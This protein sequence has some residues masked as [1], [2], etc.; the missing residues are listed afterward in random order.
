M[1]SNKK[2]SS[3][4]PLHV[5]LFE[6]GNRPMLFYL[7]CNPVVFATYH[8]SIMIGF[9]ESKRPMYAEKFGQGEKSILFVATIH[10]N[11]WSGYPILQA[12]MQSP[13][14][15]TIEK[16]ISVILVPI[17]NPDAFAL[18]ERNN[19]NWVDINRNFPSENYGNSRR[20]G[21]RFFSEQESQVLDKL[22]NTYQVQGI[23][24]FHE[25]FACIDY[26]GPAFEWAQYV[27][28]SSDLQ[29]EKLSDMSGSIGSYYGDEKK[30]PILTI[31]LPPYS[32]VKPID[33]LWEKYK[34]LLFASISFW[35]ET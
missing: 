11:E 14:I 12:F 33:Y 34:S 26:N 28:H 1:L 6:F 30:I 13:E 17:A 31:E 4:F 16:N 9:S 21:E 29:V 23:V 3:Y 19:I 22:I 5:L 32:H 7:F 10:G 15:Q 20:N 27:A 35:Y 18:Q 25:P 24:T 2:Y 8:E